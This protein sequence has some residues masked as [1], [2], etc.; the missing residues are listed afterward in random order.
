MTTNGYFVAT[1]GDNGNAGTNPATAWATIAYAETTA[2]S[3]A[4]VYVLPGTYN[5]DVTVNRHSVHFVG[6]GMPVVRR[7]E[8]SS[9]TNVTIKDFEFTHVNTSY[10]DTIMYGGTCT[11]ILIEGNYIHNIRGRVGEGSDIG[12]LSDSASRFIIVRGNTISYPGWIPGVLSENDQSGVDLSP[13]SSSCL[14]E[15]NTFLRVLDG[16]HG[17]GQQ[18]TIRNNTYG[19]YMTNYWPG[20]D[21]LLG[22]ADIFQGGSDS[23]QC[24]QTFHRRLL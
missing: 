4:T 12:Y 19:D 15:Y 24:C 21:Y 10:G 1:T 22:H 11:N 3:G 18:Q 16:V 9:V 7:F 2:P 23:G 5:E 17:Y 8:L 6:V 14:V 13:L 20:D